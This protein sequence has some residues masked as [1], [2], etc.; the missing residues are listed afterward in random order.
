MQGDDP[1]LCWWQQPLY[2]DVE[3]PRSYVEVSRVP[4]WPPDLAPDG[5]DGGP[6]G[7]GDGNG[8]GANGNGNGQ[9]VE[10]E[11]ELSWVWSMALRRWVR[12]D[13][14]EADPSQESP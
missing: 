4:A 1:A 2:L 9:P 5:E 14:P 12:R 8:N 6:S 13:E 3:N 7:N 10:P 11:S